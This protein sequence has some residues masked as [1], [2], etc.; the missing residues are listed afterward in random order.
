MDFNGE[1]G[2]PVYI[3]FKS[4]V[5]DV[6]SS[7]LWSKG[8]HQASHV[9]GYDLTKSILNAPHSE[10]VLSKF[11]VIGELFEEE[12]TRSRSA[13]LLQKVHLHPIAVHFSTAYSITAFLLALLYLFM[14]TPSFDVASYYLLALGLLS[15]PVSILFGIFSWKT[16]YKSKRNKL[17][18]RKLIF[19]AIFLIIITTCF[20]LRAFYPQILITKTYVSFLYISLLTSLTPIVTILGYYGGKI[21]YG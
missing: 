15:A 9:G 10:V 2:K 13:N 7:R 20:L 3:A 11:Q 16:N 19:A 4:K 14:H 12:T 6:S 5:Y 17:F 8:R 21:I 1:D 18:T